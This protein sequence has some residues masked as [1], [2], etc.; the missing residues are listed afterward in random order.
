MGNTGGQTGFENLNKTI[1]VANGGN[2]TITV[3]TANIGDTA[4]PS[5]TLINATSVK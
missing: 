4:V 3:K 5:A 2:L 1:N